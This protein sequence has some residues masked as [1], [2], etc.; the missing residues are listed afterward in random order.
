MKTWFLNLFKNL[1]NKKPNAFTQV[2][3]DYKGYKITKVIL[4][5]SIYHLVNNTFFLPSSLCRQQRFRRPTLR[6]WQTE[7]CQFLRMQQRHCLQASL[8]KRNPFQWPRT[9][10]RLAMERQVRTQAYP[11]PQNPR[12]R[13]LRR[14]RRRISETY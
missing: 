1:Q 9:Q 8:R 10:M 14:F 13:R 5:S 6:S 3:N 2:I 7:L 4:I 11:Q 12:T